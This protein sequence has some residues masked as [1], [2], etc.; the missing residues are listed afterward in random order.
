MGIQSVN[1]P[2]TGRT[3]AMDVRGTSSTRDEVATLPS[4]SRATGQ[5]RCAGCGYGIT[6]HAELP[7]CPMC[8]GDTWEQAAWSP[9]THALE[10]QV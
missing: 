4:G 7:R 1:V 3:I 10:A 9:I 5:Y 8:G 2:L 6:L